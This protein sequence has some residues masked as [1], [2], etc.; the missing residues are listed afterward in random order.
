[1]YKSVVVL[2]AVFLISACTIKQ[3]VEPSDLDQDAVLCIVEN[4]EVREG[5]LQELKD[6]LDSKRILY[7]LGDTQQ[8]NSDCEWSLTYTANWRWDLALYMAYANIKIYRNGVLDGE[9]TYD[10]SG[11]GANMGKFIDAE[12]K[13][14]EL[15]DQ[16]L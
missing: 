12:T 16:L 10:S 9:A 11:G 13:I 6:V 5:F 4:P 14:R 2:S 15:L 3:V 7:S 1:M 8:A